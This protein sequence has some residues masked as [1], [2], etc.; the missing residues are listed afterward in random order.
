MPRAPR[1]ACG[2]R[3]ASSSFSTVW[4]WRSPP[5]RGGGARAGGVG[6][7]HFISFLFAVPSFFDPAA[8]APIAFETAIGFVLPPLGLPPAPA[9]G[10]LRA[11]A[12]P[13]RPRAGGERPLARPPAEPEGREFLDFVHPEDRVA[14]LDALARL[15][16][17]EAV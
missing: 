12:A 16:R 10:G 2:R 14:T 15:G 6:L 7:L 3:R 8:R 11:P 1:S 17:G 5:A 9:P 4:R 13:R